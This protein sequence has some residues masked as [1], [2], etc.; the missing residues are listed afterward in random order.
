MVNLQGQISQGGKPF[1][2]VPGKKA[3][4]STIILKGF[5]MQKT[6]LKSLSAEAVGGK[7]PFQF[8]YNHE[9]SL[10]PANSGYWTV[11]QNGIKVWRLEIVSPGAYARSKGI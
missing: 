2:Y 6:I 7:K 8:A 4:A 9:V 3:K 5:E 11:M 10:S 1:P